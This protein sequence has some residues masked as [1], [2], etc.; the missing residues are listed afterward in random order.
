M[1]YV[2]IINTA[3]GR[4]QAS[5]AVFESQEAARPVL[6]RMQ[7]QRPRVV[8]EIRPVHPDVEAILS[9]PVPETRLMEDYDNGARS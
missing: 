1:S 4:A 6:E 3:N 2:Q 8:L 7:R 5:G 9:E